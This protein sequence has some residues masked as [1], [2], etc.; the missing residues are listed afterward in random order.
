MRFFKNLMTRT[1]TSACRRPQRQLERQY[2]PKLERLEQRM[3]PSGLFASLG[4]L[5]G[6]CNFRT[7]R[8]NGLRREHQDR[9]AV[10]TQPR[11]KDDHRHYRQ[12]CGEHRQGRA[13]PPL[14][15]SA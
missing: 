14:P 1:Q 7:I 9:R 8:T 10:P 13:S 11:L 12:R 2:R 6:A 3:A 4:S 15:S 5:G